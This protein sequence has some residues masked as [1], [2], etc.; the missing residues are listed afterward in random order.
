LPSRELGAWQVISWVLVLSAPVLLPIVAWRV[1]QV[2]L[3]ASPAA[4]L[5]FAY[6]SL[7]SMYLGFFAWYYALA[8]GGVAR[9][10]QLQLAQ[11]VLTML[12]S[13]MLLGERVTWEMALAA[14]G[15]LGSVALTQRSRVLDRGPS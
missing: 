10:G 2:G 7:V 11:P 5:G 8:L 1:L 15:V 13:A 12:W 9:I 4:W 14:A 6:V 3:S